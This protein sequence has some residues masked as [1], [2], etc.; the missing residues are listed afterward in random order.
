MR[1]TTRE[2][3]QA[4]LAELEAEISSIEGQGDYYLS[5]WVS[6]CKPSGK[7]QA[8]PRV[9][10]R[11]AQFKGKKVLHIK[12]SESIV[13]YQER[14]DR[15]QRIGRLQKRAERIEAKLNASSNAAQ[16]LMGAQP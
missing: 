1:D 6:K 8:Y 7:A 4:E 10:S 12:Q 5:A 3:L 15:G 2:R 9:Q 11:I 13:V 14:C 16:A